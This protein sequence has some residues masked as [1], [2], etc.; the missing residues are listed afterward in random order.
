M[1]YSI[2]L[3]DADNTL[4]DFSRSERDAL[5]ECLCARGIEPTNQILSRYAEINDLHWKL[6]ERGLTTRE[7]LRTDRF[8]EFFGEMGLTLDPNQM[9]DDYLVAL[10]S[11]AYCMDGAENLIRRLAGRCRLFIITNGNASVQ[12]A[13]FNSTSM[14]PLFEG[15]FISEELGVSKPDKRFFDLVADSIK[16]FDPRDAL[17]IGDSLSS[18]ILGGI[19]AGIDTCWFNRRGIDAPQDMSITYTV[20]SLEE[21]ESILLS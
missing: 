13:R 16:D 15:V 8:A 9:A 19:H 11:K 10:S 14:A 21:V 1:S 3:F 6:L 2:A 7:K 12:N 4:L 17:V 5:S 18:D 20:R